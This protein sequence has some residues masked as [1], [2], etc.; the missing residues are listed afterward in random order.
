MKCDIYPTLES[1]L[2]LRD[3]TNFRF[4]VHHIHMQVHCVRTADQIII[5]QVSWVRRY[6]KRR[7][8]L[9]LSR[10]FF[11]SN[12]QWCHN[13]FHGNGDTF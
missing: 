11:T 2:S 3:K 10:P 7:Q 13:G 12:R 1:Q 8:W 9:E 4:M 5:V 6:R